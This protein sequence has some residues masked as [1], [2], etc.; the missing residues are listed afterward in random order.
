MIGPIRCPNCDSEVERS[1]KYCQECGY[2]LPWNKK[3]GKEKI[4]PWEALLTLIIFPFIG[5]IFLGILGAILGIIL[6]LFAIYLN[7]LK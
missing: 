7:K 2:E 4:K 5:G 6:A 3:N 1:D